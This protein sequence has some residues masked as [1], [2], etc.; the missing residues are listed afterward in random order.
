MTI[1]AIAVAAI[2]L[3]GLLYVYATRNGRE[4]SDRLD[5]EE[6]IGSVEEPTDTAQAC[7]AQRTYDELRR[8]LF[9]KAAAIRGRDEA[10]FDEIARNAMLSVDRPRLVESE[11]SLGQLRCSGTLVVV[12]PPGLST[13]NGLSQL[14]GEAEYAVQA[15][16]DG[17]GTTVTLLSG[18]SLTATLATLVRKGSAPVATQ[19]SVAAP[20]VL[21]PAPSQQVPAVPEPQRPQQTAPTEAQ[22][23]AARPSFNCAYARTRGERAVC[24]SGPLA[25]LDRRM[26][27]QYVA[28]MRDAGPREARLLQTTRDRF[29][30]YRDRCGS[31]QCI[32]DT[33]RGR[34]REIGDIMSRN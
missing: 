2:V 27:A 24:A 9:R 17:S 22:R 29:L 23:S 28:A 33:Y 26:A 18:E 30:A 8:E 34:M 7:A 25:D 15:A 6:V 31:D 13:G 14:R 20:D 19:P 1:I 10:V 4:P 32:A 16:A 11:E 21:L 3:I 12:L 5:D